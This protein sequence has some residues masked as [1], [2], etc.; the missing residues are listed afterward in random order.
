MVT[1]PYPHELTM[2]AM[3]ILI[4]L[5]ILLTSDGFLFAQV[6]GSLLVLMAVVRIVAPVIPRVRRLGNG[7][8][9]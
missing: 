2:G 3:W 8:D 6:A 5:F 1:M 7:D 9:G 4:G